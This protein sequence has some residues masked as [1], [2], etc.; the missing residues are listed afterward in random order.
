[1]P[2]K[3]HEEQRHKNREDILS[4]AEEVFLEND[5]S[6][7]GMKDI[8]ARAG[9][10]RVTV[11]KHFNSIDE[12]AFEVQMQLMCSLNKFILSR[13]PT[14]GSAIERLYQQLL[15]WVD[16]AREHPNHFRYM[17]FFDHY[18]RDRY[19]SEELRIRY[20]RFVTEL[21]TPLKV[22]REGVQDGTVRTDLD[23]ERVSATIVH[24]MTSLLQR[25]TSRGEIIK[26]QHDV[27][28]LELSIVQVSMII[29]SIM[30]TPTQK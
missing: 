11:Y 5:F 22:L 8:V 25:I 18:Y 4:A 12:L 20:H 23:L 7:V 1:M 17:G 19:P 14:T 30:R 27:D 21:P 15:G 29:Q 16:Y 2:T 9:V 26:E 3:W 24:S 6:G 10:S 13:S 28:P